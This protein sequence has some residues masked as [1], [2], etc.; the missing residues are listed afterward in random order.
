MLKQRVITAVVL[1]AILLPALFWPGGSWPLASVAGLLLSAAAWEWGRL[2]GLSQTGA[3]ACGAACAGLCAAAAVWAGP[4]FAAWSGVWAAASVAWIV[5]SA[6]LITVGVG[7]W[8]KVGRVWRIGLGVAALVVAWCAAVALHSR[9]VWF[10]LSALAVVWIADTAAYM[11]G[12]TLSPR[13]PAKLAPAISPGKTRVGAVSGW[14]GVCLVAACVLASP[15]AAQMTL[16]GALTTAGVALGW[17]ALTLLV[18]M[19]IVGDLVESLVKRSAGAKDSSGL[20]P[21]HGGVLD[22]IDALLPCLPMTLW[23]AESLGR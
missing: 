17:A 10:L 20:L 23:L 13:F 12:K 4:T 11:G 7:G 5:L 18:A 19:S 14:L 8:P 15:A 3:V 6:W 1:L 9:G 22:R 16:V 21:G 2:N